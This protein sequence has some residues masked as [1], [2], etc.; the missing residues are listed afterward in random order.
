MIKKESIANC[1]DICNLVLVNIS[2][3]GRLIRCP[4]TNLVSVQD[5]YVYA[6]TSEMF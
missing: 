4:S 1:K 3:H 6:D 2:G 5:L